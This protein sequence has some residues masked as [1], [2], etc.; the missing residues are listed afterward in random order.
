LAWMAFTSE[1]RSKALMGTG[2]G[3]A[4]VG[5]PTDMWI[6]NLV[7]QDQC[8]FCRVQQQYLRAT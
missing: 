3:L 2:F 5:G 8:A 1:S 7:A 4:M 6:L